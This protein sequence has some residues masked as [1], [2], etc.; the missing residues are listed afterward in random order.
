LWGSDHAALAV[1]LL[2]E[3]APFVNQAHRSASAP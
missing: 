2:I 3:R 1:S